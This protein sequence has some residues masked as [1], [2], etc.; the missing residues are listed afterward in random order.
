MR[1]AFWNGLLS[2]AVLVA[3]SAGEAH[4][5]AE[6]RHETREAVLVDAAAVN[7]ARVAAWKQEGFRA[8]VVVLDDGTK[9]ESLRRAADTLAA[10]SLDL[11]CWIEVARNPTMAR[12][13]P[14]WMAS[15]GMHHEWRARFPAVRPL[16][17]GEVGKVWPWVPIGYREAFDAHRTRIATLLKRVPVGCRGILLNDIQ[18]GPASC[19]CG[20][21][22]C[23]WAFDYRV[24]STGAKLDEKDAAARFVEEIRKSARGM[25]VVPI[26]TVE[27]Q[28]ED[29]PA[30]KRP[31]GSWGTD[32]CNGVDCFNT[33]RKK[34]AEQWTALQSTHRGDMGLLLLH[35]EF[36]R[37]HKQ[38]GEPVG[39]IRYAVDY[40]EK[41][42]TAPLPKEKLW[43]VVQGYDVPEGEE[44]AARRLAAKS[45]PGWVLVART[46]IDQS[47]EPRILPVKTAP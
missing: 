17:K 31:A 36:R 14:E 16:E 7:P 34:M 28:Q 47:F 44:P 45:R 10:G 21:L 40:L 13:H 20:N 46:R 39:W 15:L 1:P 38:Y 9:P 32:Y 29:L 6:A 5:Q 3:A 41:Q 26:W 8:A 23:R 11:Y 4:G 27:C 12:E 35:R 18:G 33:C 24:A 19:G 43:L 2:C 25:Q 30:A 37:D 22:Q 42:L